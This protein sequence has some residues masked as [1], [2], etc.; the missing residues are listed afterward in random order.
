[1]TERTLSLRLAASYMGTAA[2]ALTRCISDLEEAK[3]LS[4]S[5]TRGSSDRIAQVSEQLWKAGEAARRLAAELAAEARD[6]A[7]HVVRPEP[8]KPEG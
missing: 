5:A 8:G 7:P 4:R 1:M 2:D 3:R 6:P